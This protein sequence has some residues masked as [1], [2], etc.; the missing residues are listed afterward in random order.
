MRAAPCC[1][2][3]QLWCSQRWSATAHGLRALQAECREF[4]GVRPTPVSPLGLL[5][6]RESRGLGAPCRGD[7]VASIEQRR[8]TPKTP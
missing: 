4:D 6:A 8:G 2:K 7:H 5:E 3:A 1:Y